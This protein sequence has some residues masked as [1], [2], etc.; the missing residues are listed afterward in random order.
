M[1]CLEICAGTQ[2]FS[3][4]AAARGMHTVTVDILPDYN[5]THCVDL[6]KWNEDTYPPGHFQIVWCS[7]ECTEYSQ[8]LTTRPR[9]L[10]KADALANRCLDLLQKYEAE[11]AAVLLENPHTSWLWKRIPRAA[12]MPF[13][14]VDYC[15]YGSLLKKR[16]RIAG[17]VQGI[18]TPRLCAGSGQCLS[19]RGVRHLRVAK[20]GGGE[21]STPKRFQWAVPKPLIDALINAIMLHRYYA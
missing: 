4:A 13:I 2:S 18:I 16:T 3:K 9:D 19:K 6:L 8:A 15:A 17:N 11:G 10:P 14:T 20:R 21:Q 12:A 1:N 5:P 7:T